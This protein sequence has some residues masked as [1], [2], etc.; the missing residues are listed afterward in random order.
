MFCSLKP[1]IV[2]SLPFT[3]HFRFCLHNCVNA[4]IIGKAFSRGPRSRHPRRRARRSGV[5]CI[6]LRSPINSYLMM[7]R[8]PSCR[9]RFTICVFIRATGT[10][11][12]IT[13]RLLGLIRSK[14]MY[15]GI[16]MS[17]SLASS[18]FLAQSIWRHF[19]MRQHRSVCMQLFGP[20]RLFVQN[21]NLAAC[22]HGCC[23]NMI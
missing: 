12:S 11:R 8:S 9:G 22:Q 4:S 16:F 6:R 23:A 2:I 14:R 17:Q 20:L 5:A 3:D 10:T 15:R 19:L 13:L 1:F 21:G 18:I 7:S